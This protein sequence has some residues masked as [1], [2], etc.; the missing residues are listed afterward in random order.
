MI[1]I[2]FKTFQSEGKGKKKQLVEKTY[3]SLEELF[4]VSTDSDKARAER[5]NLFG[6]W[7]TEVK[8]GELVKADSLL[9]K[10]NSK[11]SEFQH[12]LENLSRLSEYL[13]AV[14]QEQDAKELASKVNAMTD[15]QIAVLMQ[16]IEVRRNA[17]KIGK[18][19][20]QQLS[21][22]TFHLLTIK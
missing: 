2:N 9:E 1:T 15:E 18:G 5:N 21:A 7:L 3:Q 12:Y 6:D 4:R 20:G 8:D 17:Q 22:T 11:V 19:E 14:K 13:E 16:A 10:V